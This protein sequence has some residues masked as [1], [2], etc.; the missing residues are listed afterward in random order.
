MLHALS[1]P[2]LTPYL[3]H[4]GGDHEKALRLYL[5]NARLSAALFY[6]IHLAEVTLRNVI[7]EALKT[8]LNKRWISFIGAM[9]DRKRPLGFQDVQKPG[10]HTQRNPEVDKLHQARKIAARK[11]NTGQSKVPHDAIVSTIALGFWVGLLR[12][13][14]RQSIWTPC[15]QGVFNGHAP[16]D[17]YKA[18]IT[19][20]DLR[21]RIAH[22]EPIIFMP[23]N[24]LKKYYTLREQKN[25]LIDFVAMMNEKLAIHMGDGCEFDCILDDYFDLHGIDRGNIVCAQVTRYRPKDHYARLVDSNDTAVEYRC[26]NQVVRDIAP[27]N[28]HPT[29]IMH[30][31]ERAI[32]LVDRHQNP[33]R[34]L[35]ILEVW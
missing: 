1:T 34:V 10:G 24:G 11:L 2:R 15:L 29:S 8:H 31:G 5:W 23:R 14:Y 4:S 17:V 25:N 9:N 19:L 16:D 18:A 12:S 6:H 20:S 30:K 22:H 3:H 13:K 27:P 35:E 7:D 26:D 33:A 21:N 28:A 32:C